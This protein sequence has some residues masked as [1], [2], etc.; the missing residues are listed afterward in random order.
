MHALDPVVRPISGFDGI[1]LIQSASRIA[2]CGTGVS[3]Q[4]HRV[5]GRV[6]GAASLR[7]RRLTNDDVVMG[8]IDDL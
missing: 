5:G 1:G 8:K 6:I 3:C 2:G 4:E 7:E